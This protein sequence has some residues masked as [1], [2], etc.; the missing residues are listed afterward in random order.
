MTRPFQ[1]DAHV[2]L[3]RSAIAQKACC[4][5]A[6][7]ERNLFLTRGEH[8]RFRAANDP[9]NFTYCDTAMRDNLRGNN[10]APLPRGGTRQAALSR[11]TQ[12][13]FQ[14]NWGHSCIRHD[15]NTQ[16]FRH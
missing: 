14:F 2:G 4:S 3:P 9:S 11:N 12:R 15:M 5:R 16:T 6:R 8:I 10:L 1:N 7:I 13:E